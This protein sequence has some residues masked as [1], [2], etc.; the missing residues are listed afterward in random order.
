[1]SDE[2]RPI[3]PHLAATAFKP[4]Q[5]GNSGGRPRGLERLV[6]ETVGGDM[7]TIIKAQ[8]A[9]ATG[10]KPDIGIEIPAIKASD[11]TKAAEWLGDRGW[12]KARQ[13][14]DLSGD[15]AG[16]RR[17]DYSKLSDAEI[18]TLL[19]ADELLDA[20]ATDEG[21]GSPSED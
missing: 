6:R 7:V 19:K 17:I 9:I 5:S 13:T 14:V 1:V 10:K 18:E 8:I 3:P 21:D 11:M 2:K 15:T 12:G 16:A 20:A 4:G